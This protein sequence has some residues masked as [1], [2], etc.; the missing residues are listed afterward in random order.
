MCNSLE[1]DNLPETAVVRLSSVSFP[2]N[3]IIS[4]EYVPEEL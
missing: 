1:T 3:V 2:V 4:S